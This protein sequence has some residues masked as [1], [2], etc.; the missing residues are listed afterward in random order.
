LGK[1]RLYELLRLD[2]KS[3]EAPTTERKGFDTLSQE[4]TLQ[5]KLQFT[6]MAWEEKSAG[7]HQD[8]GAKNAEGV[9]K[10]PNDTAEFRD[11]TVV[12]GKSNSQS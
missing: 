3:E 9:S 6:V 5:K 2:E 10:P 4:R 1:W 12:E 7:G 8:K 11:G